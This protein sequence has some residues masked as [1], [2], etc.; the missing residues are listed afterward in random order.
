MI[1]GVTG[2][3][4]SG[5]DTLVSFFEKVGFEHISLSDY[6]RKI[7]LTQNKEITREN[8][9][10]LGN[11]LRS[12][13]G[14]DYLASLAIKELK[15]SNKKIIISSI[16]RVA[17]I[18]KLKELE[19]FKLIFVDANEKIRFKRASKRARESE[20]KSFEEFIKHDMLERTGGNGLFRE[21]D[22]CKAES[23]FIVEN[24]GSFAKFKQK[25]KDIT[26]H[27]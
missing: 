14:D 25:I 18:K 21:F 7:L 27:L 16:G 1:I 26:Q 3:K 8:L 13:K 12:S 2:Y 22:N 11:E 24:N 5:K 4:A 15:G 6:L 20:H 9:T 23:D 10:V 17:E 19:G